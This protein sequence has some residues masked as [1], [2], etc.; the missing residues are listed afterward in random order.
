MPPIKDDFAD[1]R[2]GRRGLR[3]RGEDMVNWYCLLT[4]GSRPVSADESGLE[5]GASRPGWKRLVGFSMGAG[6][7]DQKAGT[8]WVRKHVPREKRAGGWMGDRRRH[9]VQISFGETYWSAGMEWRWVV[10]IEAP[11]IWAPCA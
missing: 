7:E 5:D 3:A 8:L 1:S 4:G 6:T 9:S 11:V 2:P 10:V